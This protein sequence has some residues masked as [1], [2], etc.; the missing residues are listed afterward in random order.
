MNYDRILTTMDF[1]CV[2]PDGG[3]SCGMVSPLGPLPLGFELWIYAN[4]SKVYVKLRCTESSINNKCYLG[5]T[6]L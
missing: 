1:V 3:F 4:F 5:D 2:V 6:G